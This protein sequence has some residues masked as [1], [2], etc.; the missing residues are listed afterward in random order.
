MCYKGYAIDTGRNFIDAI[1]RK[2]R[3]LDHDKTLLSP[4]GQDI[5]GLQRVI[6]VCSYTWH[7]HVI[8]IQNY[9]LFLWHFLAYNSYHL[10]YPIY[11]TKAG[12]QNF[13]SKICC[14]SVDE[15]SFIIY[16]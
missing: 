4:Q 6:P 5:F 15:S 13:K 9:K 1:K 16:E 11:K 7:V 8:D 14:I 12:L 10:W 3:C 2:H